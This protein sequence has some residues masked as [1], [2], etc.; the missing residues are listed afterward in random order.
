[1]GHQETKDLNKQPLTGKGL[2]SEQLLSVGENIVDGT[3]SS[4]SEQELE[5]ITA[6]LILI[7]DNQLYGDKLGQRA[8]NIVLSLV[9][10]HKLLLSLVIE[11]AESYAKTQHIDDAFPYNPNSFDVLGKI[12]QSHKKVISFLKDIVN[13][14]GIPR[15]EAINSLCSLNNHTADKVLVE[16]IQ[17]KYPPKHLDL[18][19]DLRCIEEAK[20]RTFVSKNQH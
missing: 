14:W 8:F 7:Y 6:Q 16:I 5:D 13:D 11:N 18:Q 15:W 1:M 19:S 17:G 3:I 10:Q 12:R 20:G 2:G 9:K 4:V